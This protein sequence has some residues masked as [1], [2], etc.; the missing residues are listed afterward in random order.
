MKLEEILTR[1][2]FPAE[3][4]K[5]LTDSG[6]QNLYPPQVSAVEKGILDG[7]NL[8]LS[9]PTAAGKTLIAELC[10]LKAILHNEGRCLYIA[11]LKALA[12]EKY[13][14]FKKKYEPLGIKVGIAT[15]DLDSPN[16]FLNR[17]QI[18]IATAEKVDSLLRSRA[19]W[20]IDSL[21][22]VV[23]DEIHFINDGER[24]PTLEILTARMK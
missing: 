15:G 18:L 23:L 11:P 2:N 7:K 20:L 10:M 9:V 3:V 16:K 21:N 8:L 14:D 1:Y 19:K 22:V 17:Y 4:I 13:E 12:S 6:I 5:I 24:G